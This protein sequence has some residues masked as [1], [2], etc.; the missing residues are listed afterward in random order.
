MLFEEHLLL[1]V[2]STSLLFNHYFERQSSSFHHVTTQGLNW[3]VIHKMHIPTMWIGCYATHP[4]RSIRYYCFCSWCH[5]TQKLLESMFEENTWQYCHKS[6]FVINGTIDGS[7]GVDLLLAR[8]DELLDMIVGEHQDI[9][10]SPWHA[11]RDGILWQGLGWKIIIT[12]HRLDDIRKL[13]LF[14]LVKVDYWWCADLQGATGTILEDHQQNACCI[15]NVKPG[16]LWI[17]LRIEHTIW[18]L[19]D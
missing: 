17:V 10:M 14:S 11:A 15:G 1:W 2:T 19:Q 4:C 3:C 7:Y 9:C 13:A 6:C 5:P 8:M 16:P 12:H 18:I